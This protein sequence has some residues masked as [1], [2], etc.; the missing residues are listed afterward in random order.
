VARILE[1]EM[2]SRRPLGIPVDDQL[3]GA[4]LLLDTERMGEHVQA[5]FGG[6]EPL[7]SLKIRYLEYVPHTSLRVQYRAN[8]GTHKYDLTA[9]VGFAVSEDDMKSATKIPAEGTGGADSNAYL[10]WYPIDLGLPMLAR[11]DAAIAELLGLDSTGPTARMAWVP[12]QRAAL[13]YPNA[14]V[15][16]Y[17][18]PVDAMA[19]ASALTIVAGHI[20]TARLLHQ[21]VDAGLVAQELL[22]GNALSH[23]DAFPT[24]FEAV[25]VLSR[26]HA[27]DASTFDPNILV[28]T[29]TSS[30]LLEVL[31][32]PTN[33]VRFCRPDLADRIDVVVDQLQ[34]YLPHLP[35][36]VVSHGDFNVGQLLRGSGTT[37]DP[38]NNLLSV[39]DFD[40]LC[41]APPAFDVASYAANLMS[42]RPEDFADMM[43]A[44][45]RVLQV[46]P[47]NVDG[48]DWY[49]AAMMMRRLDRPVRR[50]KRD[51]FGRTDVILASAERCLLGF[52]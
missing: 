14:I 2:S 6:V 37:R 24:I 52:N 29:S 51:W 44:R 33:L 3:Q 47:S 19:A 11:S 40:T 10:T 50:L 20:P 27:L 39:L 1:S 21:N 35:Q 25:E 17:R 38:A 7:A 31:Q 9:Q 36:L 28:R 15:K 32:H 42:G 26:L 46:Y 34:R 23:N 41:L 43:A 13:R 45:D 12:G 16:V 22:V 4:S 48:M 49:L 18:D 8:I 30:N 5:S